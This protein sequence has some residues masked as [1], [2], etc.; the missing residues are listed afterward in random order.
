MQSSTQ[1]WKELHREQVFEKYSR[2]ID[3]VDFKLPNGRVA[4]FY[5][6]VE[7]PTAGILGL[8][9]HNEVIL[10]EQFRP[11]PQKVL[12]ELPG[13]FVE[14]GE[15]QLETA[16]REFAEETG[17]QGDFEFVGRCLDDA[18]STM[19]RYCFVAR[20]C[21]KISEPQHTVTEQ[22]RVVLLPLDKFRDLLRSGQLTDVD[23]GYL[24]LDYLGLL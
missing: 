8:T 11:G 13:G 21:Q 6:K 18:Y 9:D 16:K 22:T 7:G 19:Q 1:P 3:K 14:P 17:Y 4:D 15:D 20:N 24:A 2:R 23:V 12:L 10:A 5:I